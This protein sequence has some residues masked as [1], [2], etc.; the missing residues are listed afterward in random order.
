MQPLELQRLVARGAGALPDIMVV[1]V[2][3]LLRHRI[4]YQG[5]DDVVQQVADAIKRGR[6]RAIYVCASPC[7]PHLGVTRNE[8]LSAMTS[9]CADL[10][11]S[12]C[13]VD[14]EQPLVGLVALA[15]ESGFV[16]V[17]AHV[18]DHP[19]ELAVLAWGCE[20]VLD[21]ATGKVWTAA[22]VTREYCTPTVIAH[23]TTIA[24]LDTDLPPI[25]KEASTELNRSRLRETLLT[26]AHDSIHSI[27]AASTL[28]T[29]VKKALNRTK[30]GIL[31]DRLCQLLARTPP[32]EKALSA[33]RDGFEAS[34]PLRAGEPPV[35]WRPTVV[36]DI[37]TSDNSRN[38]FKRLAFVAGPPGQ[39]EVV[40]AEGHGACVDLLRALGDWCFF[41][42]QF[43][44]R[45]TENSAV[46]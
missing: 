27:V 29:R 46:V 33:F 40:E 38:V 16:I 2:G 26:G 34:T 3:G 31:M 1:D 15:R 22:N 14:S 11:D 20:A 6:R 19:H 41:K 5:A 17:T 18:E 32:D 21:V 13:I 23:F 25:V 37:D 35:P 24:G 45:C 36:A 42:A 8:L 12:A 44:L 43:I 4:D 30:A 28:P 10:E 39:R 9:A 7:V